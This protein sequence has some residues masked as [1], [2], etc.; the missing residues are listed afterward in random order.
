MKIFYPIKIESQDSLIRLFTSNPTTL[1]SKD[2]KTINLAVNSKTYDI[3][4]FITAS[5]KLIVSFC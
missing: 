1:I 3:H 2:L 5:L 4:L